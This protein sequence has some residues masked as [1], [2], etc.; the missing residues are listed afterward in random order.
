MTL[1]NWHIT[2]SNG[3]VQQYH[4]VQLKLKE[5]YKQL[6]FTLFSLWCWTII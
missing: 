1:G 2:F 4:T 5:I 3:K 6:Y